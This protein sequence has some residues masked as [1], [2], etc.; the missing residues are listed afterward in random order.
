M[1]EQVTFFLRK[2]EREPER[3]RGFNLLSAC[4]LS[5]KLKQLISSIIPIAI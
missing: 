2:G 4:V 5:R 3:H 1:D